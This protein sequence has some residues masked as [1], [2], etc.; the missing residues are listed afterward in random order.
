MSYGKNGAGLAGS[1]R[2]IEQQVRKTVFIDKLANCTLPL[3]HILLSLLCNEVNICNKVNIAN[4]I[5]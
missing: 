1:R 5:K 3:T 4:S 2:S